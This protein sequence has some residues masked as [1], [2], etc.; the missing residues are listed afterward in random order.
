[1]RKPAAWDAAEGLPTAFSKRAGGPMFDRL[2]RSS[3]YRGTDGS[4][5][6][7]TSGGLTAYSV[8]N[9]ATRWDAS[10]SYR[11]NKRF[12]LYVEGRNLTNEA[13]SWYATTPN[14]PEDYIYTGAI[15]TGGIKFRF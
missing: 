15:Y 1:M 9:K 3:V 10:L 7:R 5:R 11:L 14:R 6:V 2:T 12:T 13:A 4:I 8:A